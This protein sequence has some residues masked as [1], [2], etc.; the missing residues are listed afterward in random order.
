VRRYDEEAL[1]MR[2]NVSRFASLALVLTLGLLLLGCPSPTGGGGDDT[3]A[4]GE[5]APADGTD[6]GSDEGGTEAPEAPLYGVSYDGNGADSG[7][8]PSD[9]NEYESGDTVTVLGNPG[10]LAKAGYN[11]HGWN[12]AADQSGS[13]YAEGSQ[14]TISDGDITLYARWLPEGG[15]DDTDTLEESVPGDD[16]DETSGAGD[17]EAPEAPLY[18][19]SYDG[20]G[21][22]S[23]SPPSDENEYES[24]DTVT[25]LG[26]PGG[27]AK[28]GH[29]FKGWNTAADQSGTSYAAGSELTISD[30]DITLYA[31]WLP[32]G[33]I[34][35]SFDN[36]EDPEILF[37]GGAEEL[38]KSDDLTITASGSY[39]GHTW[40]L[41]GDA[42]HPGLNSAGASATIDGGQ[43][44]YGTHT[45]SLI[46]AEGYSAQF[47]FD[48]VDTLSQ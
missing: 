23:G 20:N 31:R 29:D 42:S 5:P 21:A 18:G 24:G 34:A 45:V 16:T 13:T 40:Y 28:A 25:V 11:F 38:L 32:E 47:S 2:R 37:S 22:D 26:N 36:P 14:L 15:G 4:P 33:S 30:G 19:V 6:G 35:I 17:T 44:G 27:L 8:P 7:S 10:G 9:E 12:T 46:V 43:L 39:S 3:A 1:D 48:V 41:D